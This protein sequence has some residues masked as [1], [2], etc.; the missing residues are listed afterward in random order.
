SKAILSQLNAKGRLIAFDQDEDAW[1]N[2]IDDPRFILVKENFRYLERFL[3]LYNLIPVD[4]VFADLGVSSHQFDTAGRG[5]SMQQ[6]ALLDMRM[7]KR[8]SLAAKDILRSYD[9]VKL[10]EIFEKYGE[11]PNARTLAQRIVDARESF[12]ITTVAEL[13]AIAGSISKGNPQRYLAQ[14]FQA[15]RI[16]VN[17][18]LNVLREL[19]EQSLSVLKPGGRLAVITFHS[20]EDRI[21]KEFMKNEKQLNVLY[22][23]P[24]IPSVEEIK[25]NTRARSAKLRMAMKTPDV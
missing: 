23:K 14:V 24:L 6:N 4:G 5:F 22:K 20:L 7:D 11:V 10:Q 15:L 19:M 16:T 13:T 18:E 21:V 2:A 3:K 17:D 25:I 1:K 9:S 8:Q 12:P